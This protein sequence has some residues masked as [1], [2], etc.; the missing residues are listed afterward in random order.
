MEDSG[1]ALSAKLVATIKGMEVAE[2]RLFQ[3][4]WEHMQAQ[5]ERKLGAVPPEISEAMKLVLRSCSELVL[6]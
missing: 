2:L 1:R 6:D 5:Y 4:G 3:T